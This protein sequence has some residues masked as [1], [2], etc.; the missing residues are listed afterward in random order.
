MTASERPLQELLV[1]LI[2][3]QNARGGLLGRPLEPVIM[4]PCSDPKLYA[5]QA[6][7]LIA[8]HKVAVIFGCWTSAS[9]KEV[10]PIVE[11]ERSLLFYPSQN[12]GHATSP[13]LLYT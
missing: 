11:G 8:E 4:N 9:R 5:R 2:E 3:Q 7:E 1:M 12:E 6:H 10:L 13:N